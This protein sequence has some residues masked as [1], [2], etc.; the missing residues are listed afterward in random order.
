MANAV[1][2]FAAFLRQNDVAESPHNF[3]N[4]LK[5]QGLAVNVAAGD[6]ERDDALQRRFRDAINFAALDMMLQKFGERERLIFRLAA[7]EID[8]LK[9]RINRDSETLLLPAIPK[10]QD[11]R[12]LI[13]LKNAVDFRRANPV[14]EFLRDGVQNEGVH[15]DVFSCKTI[16]SCTPSCTVSF[17]DFL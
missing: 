17:C 2:N 10:N 15:S 14:C 11:K 16:C 6:V 12:L 8:K 13:R 7:R 4:Q 9:A 1:K 3:D 5:F